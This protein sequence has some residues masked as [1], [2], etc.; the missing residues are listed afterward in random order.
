M[1][2]ARE[3]AMT[4]MEVEADQLGA[5][6]IVGVRLDIEFKEFGS[7]LAEFIAVG[8]AVKSDHPAP[9]GRTWRN[10]RNQPFTSDLSGQ[11]FWTL[12]QAGYAPL[13]MVMGTC[14]YHIAHQRFWQAM[15]NIGQNVELPQFT[16]A[17]Y[18]ARELAMSRMQAEAEAAARGG[19]RRGAAA[20]A[21]RTAGAGTPRSSSRSARPCARCAP[22]TTS[23]PRSSCCR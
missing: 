16:E 13:G 12:V 20:V 18:D 8:T 21:R 6:G 9:E 22:T 15:G 14:V 5:D 10:N 4:R 23:R 19:H 3:L 2:H 11:D 7:D 1:Y 17:L